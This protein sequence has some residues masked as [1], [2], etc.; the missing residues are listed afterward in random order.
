[1]RHDNPSK[2]PWV[3]VATRPADNG[4]MVTIIEDI[5]EDIFYVGYGLTLGNVKEGGPHGCYTLYDKDDA[6][7][8]MEDMI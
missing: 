7:S 6:Y 4:H 2:N 1:M 3:I 5:D 8:K